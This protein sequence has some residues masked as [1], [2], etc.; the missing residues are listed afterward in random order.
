[1]APLSINSFEGDD[2]TIWFND[3]ITGK[4]YFDVS[5]WADAYTSIYQ[6]QGISKD[7]IIGA[8][9]LANNSIRFSVTAPHTTENN[10]QVTTEY[11]P[12][13]AQWNGKF[14]IK[15]DPVIA[16]KVRS[17]GREWG[18]SYGHIDITGISYNL[19]KEMG[20]LWS[21]NLPNEITGH[22]DGTIGEAQYNEY[23]QVQNTVVSYLS[24]LAPGSTYV[25]ST[26]NG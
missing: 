19:K 23:G 25:F 7:E 5:E 10:G 1:M 8:W 22:F 14:M 9:S 16:G 4:K 21:L 15:G 12:I 26:I 17:F 18:R 24:T 13:Y 2:F 6:Q 20:S 11:I 3:E